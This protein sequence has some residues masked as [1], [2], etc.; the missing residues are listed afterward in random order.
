MGKRIGDFVAFFVKTFLL[1]NF[2]VGSIVYIFASN[3]V[4]PVLKPSTMFLIAIVTAILALIENFR[5]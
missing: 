2:A 3:R 5:E 4:S 1:V